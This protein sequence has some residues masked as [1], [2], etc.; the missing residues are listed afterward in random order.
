MIFSQRMNWRP[1]YLFNF[2][3]EFQDNL[4]QQGLEKVGY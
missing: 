1:F 4:P 2:K 3:P